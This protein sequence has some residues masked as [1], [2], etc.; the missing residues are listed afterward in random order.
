MCTEPRAH[1]ATSGLS[2]EKSPIRRKETPNDC[3]TL[4][5]CTKCPADQLGNRCTK[6]Q[7]AVCK[8]NSMDGNQRKGK[9]AAYYREY[10][11]KQRAK[12]QEEADREWAEK[13][14]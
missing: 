5:V 13:L 11:K 14:V 6:L 8:A 1:A 10:R 12:R 3:Q 2:G 7:F 9:D 4:I